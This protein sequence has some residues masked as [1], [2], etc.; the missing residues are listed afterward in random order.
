MQEGTATQEELNNIWVICNYIFIG[1][2]CILKWLAK[3]TSTNKYNKLYLSCK[4]LQIQH[5]LGDIIM[6]IYWIY[7]GIT[8]LKLVPTDPE[9]RSSVLASYY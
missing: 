9:N 4:P 6:K 5:T 7:P 1:F 3:D 2:I 8:G